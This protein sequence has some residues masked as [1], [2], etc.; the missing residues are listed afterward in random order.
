ML[1]VTSNKKYPK[2]LRYGNNVKSKNEN[3]FLN[4]FHKLVSIFE[5]IQKKS[6]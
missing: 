5:I 2:P 1:K 6:V 3:N 4:K